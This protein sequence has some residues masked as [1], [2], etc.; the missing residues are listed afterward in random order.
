MSTLYVD[1]L[2]P[3]LSSNVVIP[4]HVIQ[5]VSAAIASGNGPTVSTATNNI[6]DTATGFYADITPTSS[7][8]KIAVFLTSNIQ[9]VGTG[10]QGILWGMR[11]NGTPIARHSGSDYIEYSTAESNFHRTVS[12]NHVDAPATTSSTRYELYLSNYGGGTSTVRNWGATN[13]VLMEIAQ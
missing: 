11:R 1:N 5:V 10:G 7:S 4:G 12:F 8:S 3:N 6:A 13:I 9:H 2:Q